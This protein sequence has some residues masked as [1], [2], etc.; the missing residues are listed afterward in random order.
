MPLSR[1]FWRFLRW[2][3]PRVPLAEH[4]YDLYVSVLFALFAFVALLMAG[5]AIATYLTRRI[6]RSEW[7]NRYVKCCAHVHVTAFLH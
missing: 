4:G 5:A 2:F 6:E 1:R 3:L 7:L